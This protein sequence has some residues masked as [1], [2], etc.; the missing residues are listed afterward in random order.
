MTD[1][2]DLADHVIVAE[3]R[4]STPFG[5]YA[6]PGRDPAADL[7][8]AI[9]IEV[10]QEFFD[11]SPE[12]L[13]EEYAPYDDNSLFLVVLDHRLRRPAG[14]LRILLPHGPMKS[15][16]DI[17]RGWGEST[18]EVIARTRPTMDRSTMWD[19]ATLAAMPDYRGSSTNG[20][21]TLSLYQGLAILGTQNDVKWVLA[22][23]DIV[24]LDLIQKMISRPFHPFTGL[25]P[26]RYLDSPSSLPVFLE[27]EDYQPRL[28]LTD[29]N[30]YEI[31]FDGT[32]LEAAVS[33]P[34]YR[35]SATEG[36]DAATLVTADT[37]R[38]RATG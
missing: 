10:F 32:G 6:I 34:D 19:I 35:R 31:L 27:A 33:T 17:A 29:P 20:L 21:I 3:G 15:F 18:E 11:N 24:V 2:R 26:R 1:L 37:T 7:G 28:A 13:H 14:V 5:L 16:D 22:I 23:L 9:E 12:L 36:L 4:G 25:E 30:M 8:R 38:L